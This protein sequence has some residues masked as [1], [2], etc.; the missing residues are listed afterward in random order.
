MDS[1]PFSIIEEE[2]KRHYAATYQLKPVES[3]DVGSGL[4]EK[5]ASIET[6]WLLQKLN[7]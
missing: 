4:N 5:V 6:V 7:Q 1:P 3:K 2:V